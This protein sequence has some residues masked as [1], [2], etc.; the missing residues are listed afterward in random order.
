MNLFTFKVMGIKGEI[1]YTDF[2]SEGI[3]IEIKEESLSKA[4]DKIREYLASNF[5]K[6]D[7][8]ILEKIELVKI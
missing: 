4:S 6:C 3:I 7:K 2:L 1:V 5:L 8:V